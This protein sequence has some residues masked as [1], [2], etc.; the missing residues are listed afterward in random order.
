MAE[1]ESA[2]REKLVPIL[3]AHGLVESSERGR[4]TPDTVFSRLFEVKTPSEVTEKRKALQDDPTWK[5]VLEHLGR[6]FG[7]RP[8]APPPLYSTYEVLS[9][10]PL[11]HYSTLAGPGKVVPAGA[12]RTVAAG[13]GT[14]HWRTYDAGDGLVQV[15]E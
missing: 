4:A 11:S 13:R 8:A 2:Y 14:G 5:A 3:K 6:A 10:A 7:A 1:F 12:G 15:I 9:A